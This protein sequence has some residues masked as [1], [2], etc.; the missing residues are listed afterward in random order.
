MVV[1]SR[2]TLSASGPIVLPFGPRFP[3]LVQS[4]PYVWLYE[5]EVPT[6]P[7]TMARLAAF[8]DSVTWGTSSTGTPLVYSSFPVRHRGMKQSTDASLPTVLLQVSN[9]SLEIAALVQAHAGLIGQRV[10]IFQISLADAPNGSPIQDQEFEI[11]STETSAGQVTV[12]LGHYN[13]RNSPF[14]GGRYTRDHCRFGYKTARCGYVGAL[15]SC[16]FTLNGPN[17]CV[18]HDNTERFGAFPGIPRTIGVGT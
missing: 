7:P 16:D 3:D 6:D 2:G 15:A 13:P 4:S 9:V 10:R 12:R 18:V 14:P 8:P 5:I 11:L 1:V 17:G